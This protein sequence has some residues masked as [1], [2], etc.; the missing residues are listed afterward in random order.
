MTGPH[1]NVDLFD[2]TLLTD[3][4][5]LLSELVARWAPDDEAGSNDFYRILGEVGGAVEQIRGRHDIEMDS[6]WDSEA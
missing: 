1:G 3:A 5:E 2:L 4:I 6:S